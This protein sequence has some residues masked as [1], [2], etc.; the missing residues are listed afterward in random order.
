MTA[1][2]RI[3]RLVVHVEEAIRLGSSSDIPRLRL[4]LLLLDSAAELMLHRETSYLLASET[5]SAQLLQKLQGYED[6]GHV[7]PPDLQRT[8]DELRDL[9]TPAAKRREIERYFD[10]R[11]SSSSAPGCWERRR[12]VFSASSTSIETRP[13]PRLCALEDSG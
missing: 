9:V 6:L 10:A 11:L 13:T 3:E 5:T 2:E 7:L 8:R 1:V 12:F 4:S